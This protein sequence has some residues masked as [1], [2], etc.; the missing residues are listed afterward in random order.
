MHPKLGRTDARGWP[1]ALENLLGVTVEPGSS[2]Q[3]LFGVDDF[4][5]EIPKQ[6][7]R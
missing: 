5:I 4:Q 6:Q 7:T 1:D 2:L 3:N